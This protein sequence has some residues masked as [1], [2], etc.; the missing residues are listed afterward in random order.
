VSFLRFSRKRQ[1]KICAKFF[2]GFRS[3]HLFI[4]T[5]I[6]KHCTRPLSQIRVRTWFGPKI[7]AHLSFFNKTLLQKLK[8]DTPLAH[9]KWNNFKSGE[10]GPGLN[11]RSETWGRFFGQ[12][13][14]I[15]DRL[16]CVAPNNLQMFNRRG[17]RNFCH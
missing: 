4:T 10:K 12:E 7:S 11:S 6:E 2:S 1:D 14:I 3:K 17:F 16:Y 13:G 8:H 5:C 15:A 9:G